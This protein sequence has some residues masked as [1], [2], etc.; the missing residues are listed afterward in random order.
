MRPVQRVLGAAFSE[1]QWAPLVE[2]S[3]P[4]L[5]ASYWE[6]DGLQLWTMAN[7]TARAVRGPLLPVAAVAGQRYWDLL[8]G[9]G[10]EPS[11]VGGLCVLQ[12]EIE[13]HGIA[14][15]A[16]G[17]E[18]LARRLAPLLGD[19]HE[20]RRVVRPPGPAPAPSGPVLEPGGRQVPG[21]VT[22]QGRS[23]RRVHRF[24]GCSRDMT[25]RYRMREC[26]LDEPAPLADAVF[27][28]LHEVVT[29][30]RHVTLD[31]FGIDM[32]PVTNTE[33]CR[34]LTASGYQPRC[35]DNFLLHWASPAGPSRAQAPRPVVFVDSR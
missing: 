35:A 6:A 11:E 22:D 7:T 8:G 32:R 27:P 23:R 17:P 5:H 16:A 25:L 4:G 29:E 10:V 21:R 34:F 28:A 19:R 15:F 3:S 31:P 12:G 26:G 1:G 2:T 24:A 9:V 30:T 18:G 13:A 14:G 33:F 20:P